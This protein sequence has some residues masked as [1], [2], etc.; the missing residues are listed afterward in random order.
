M[1]NEFPRIY[2]DNLY[3]YLPEFTLSQKSFQVNSYFARPQLL[4]FLGN[5]LVSGGNMEEKTKI[6]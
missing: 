3:Q 1:H 6:R 4:L 2:I 5:S